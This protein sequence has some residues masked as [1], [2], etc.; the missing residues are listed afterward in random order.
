MRKLKELRKLKGITQEKLA[1]YL[2]VVIVTVRK[3]ESSDRNPS[4]STAKK[5]QDISIKILNIY[6]R[7][8]FHLN[9]IQ[10]VLI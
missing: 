2:G 7:I 9:K 4:I 5:Y 1:K 3:I 6:F 8:F 10:S